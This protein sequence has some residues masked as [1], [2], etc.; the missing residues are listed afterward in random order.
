MTFSIISVYN[1][2]KSLKEN[3]LPSLKKQS[4]KFELILID[5][6]HNKYFSSAA[7]A[8]NSAAKKARGKY[9]VFIHQDII[10]PEKNLLKKA[11]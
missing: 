8:L 6:R 5:N 7:S 2:Q 10:F 9:F 4:L 11:N 3:L 1:D